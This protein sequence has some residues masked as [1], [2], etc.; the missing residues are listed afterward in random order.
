MH[1]LLS[2]SVNCLSAYFLFYHLLVNGL[3]LYSAFIQSA[4]QFMPLI[5]PFTHQQRLAAMQ[6]TTQFV[7]SNR[8]LGI[9]L[10]VTSTRPGWDRTGNPPTARRQLLPPELY[11]P[12]IVCVNVDCFQLVAVYLSITLPRVSLTCKV[13]S[14]ALNQAHPVFPSIKPQC[15]QSCLL[16]RTGVFSQSFKRYSTVI[17]FL[18][19]VIVSSRLV[20]VYLFICFLVSPSTLPFNVCIDSLGIGPTLVLDFDSSLP[21]WYFSPVTPGIDP[22]LSHGPDFGFSWTFLFA[23]S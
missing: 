2:T 19:L 3:H 22:R 13:D 18:S 15:A 7:R 16:D 5:H 20:L 10:R 1:A 12:H 6:G 9:L 21:T 11:Q 23:G 4:V 8:G 17:V 14:P